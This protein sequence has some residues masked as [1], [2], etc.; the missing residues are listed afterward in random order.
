[1][2]DIKLA[3]WIEMYKNGEFNSSV[4]SMIDAGWYDWF[5]SDSHLWTAF[6]SFAPKVVALAESKKVNKE[7]MYVFFKNNCP[8]VGPT[9]DDFRICDLETG[10]VQ[11]TIQN[12]KKGCYGRS[13]KT[14]WEVYGEGEWRTPLAKGT[15]RDVKKF[16]GV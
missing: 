5:C 4:K 13:E 10:D 15:W 8:C 1:M 6:K 7:T 12:I 16:F 11:Y 9:Y 2:A 3:K 14:H